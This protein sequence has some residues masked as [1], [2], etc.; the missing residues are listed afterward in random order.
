MLSQDKVTYNSGC[1]LNL[2]LSWF[3]GIR[4]F[5]FGAI[6]VMSR[7][8]ETVNLKVIQKAQFLNIR[9]LVLESCPVWASISICSN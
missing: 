7:V 3:F 1:N 6:P 9:G 2:W 5:L 4:L 8:P